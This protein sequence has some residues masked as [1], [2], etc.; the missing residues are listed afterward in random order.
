MKLSNPFRMKKLAED[1]IKLIFFLQTLKGKHILCC[2]FKA[3]QDQMIGL[4]FVLVP[5]FG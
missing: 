3:V 5:P 4:A 1:K 2:R